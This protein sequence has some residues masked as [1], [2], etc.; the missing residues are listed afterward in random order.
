MGLARCRSPVLFKSG[1]YRGKRG[2]IQHLTPPQKAYINAPEYMAIARE[3][4][5]FHSRLAEINDEAERQALRESFGLGSL[6]LPGD[7]TCPI[8]FDTMKGT[9]IIL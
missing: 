4:R 1:S 9:H 8:T 3:P 7:F 5:G 2:V 6:Q